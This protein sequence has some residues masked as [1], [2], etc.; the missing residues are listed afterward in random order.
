MPEPFNVDEAMPVFRSTVKSF[1]AYHY[2]TFGC[3]PDLND[4]A[5]EGVIY[6]S[7][8]AVKPDAEWVQGGHQPWDLSIP[9]HNTKIQVKGTMLSGKV[10]NLSSFR[11]GTHAET[12]GMLKQGL[13]THLHANDVWYI[14]VRQVKPQQP[15]MK[16]W[17]FECTKDSFLYEED[18]YNFRVVPKK[19]SFLYE[20]NKGG[21]RVTVQ[22][23]TSHQ[24]WYR[25]PFDAFQTL[26]GVRLVDSF[27]FTKDDL[28]RVL[29]LN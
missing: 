26:K 10:L 24:L 28:P 25:I 12:P 7:L 8:L 15:S 23:T 27:V 21:V 9:S 13:M 1:L 2:H 4:K 6:K 3:L 18:L 17:F 14:V 22:P 5:L 19:K 11:L 29:Y 16:V 20:C